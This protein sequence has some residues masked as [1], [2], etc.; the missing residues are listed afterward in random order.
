MSL[1]TWKAKFLPVD[2]HK[3]KKK[4]AVAHSLLK[5]SGLRTAAI[6]R[7]GVRC[8]YDAYIS[9]EHGNELRIDA[10]NCALCHWHLDVRESPDECKTCPGYKANGKEC[11]DA[12]RK[13]SQT[14][15]TAPM[16]RWLKK[17]S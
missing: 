11:V 8:L 15:E 3:C 1:E 13:F 16:I 14:G 7:H 10:D 4:D 12:Y 2:T 17:I 6:R 9:D 5:W